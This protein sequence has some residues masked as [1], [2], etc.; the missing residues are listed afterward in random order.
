MIDTVWGPEIV[1]DMTPT[2]LPGFGIYTGY[3]AVR[4]FMAEWFGA[5]DFDG[6]GNG[7]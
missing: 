5:F 6:V 7:D 4:A 1:W 3:E 2:R